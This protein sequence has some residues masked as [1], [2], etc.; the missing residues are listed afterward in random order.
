MKDFIKNKYHLEPGVISILHTFGE[1][2]N[3]HLHVHMIVSWGGIDK[4]KNKLKSIAVSDRVDYPKLKDL[5]RANMLEAI[6]KA[7]KN[8]SLERNFKAAQ[9]YNDFIGSLLKTPW[10]LHLE[11]PYGCARTSD[12]LHW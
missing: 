12:S 10:I 1:K 2:K 8:D 6:D 11:P 4:E 7:Y 3:L 9:E 5:F